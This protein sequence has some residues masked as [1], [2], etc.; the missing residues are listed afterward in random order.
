MGVISKCFY[1]Q[2]NVEIKQRMRAVF[3][4]IDIT[5]SPGKVSH[6]ISPQHQCDQVSIGESKHGVRLVFIIVSVREAHGYISTYKSIIIIPSGVLI[7]I[8]LD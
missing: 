3:R 5:A 6:G 7:I 8:S 4:V 2:L 1:T